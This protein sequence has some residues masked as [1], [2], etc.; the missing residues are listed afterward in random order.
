MGDVA[1]HGSGRDQAGDG[2]HTGAPRVPRWRPAALRPRG[3]DSC[4]A[5]GRRTCRALQGTR[6]SC[7]CPLL[8][9]V[10]C[11]LPLAD[12]RRGLLG[13]SRIRQTQSPSQPPG[14]GRRGCPQRDCVQWPGR[15]RRHQRILLEAH[16]GDRRRVAGIAGDRRRALRSPLGP[17]SGMPGVSR[18]CTRMAAFAAVPARPTPNP[19][20]HPPPAR[21]RSA[22]SRCAP[23]PLSRPSAR[24]LT[25]CRQAWPT[26][27]GASSRST[28]SCSSSARS[29]G[30]PRPPPSE[31]G[32]ER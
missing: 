14:A 5:A 16:A 23:P 12:S 27:A 20:T 7:A 8:P 25:R 3:E 2:A 11:A 10:L 17:G 30:R 6:P 22:C 19:A 26:A 21:A 29:P 18:C 28:T 9:D 1:G 32:A 4:A 24:P 15:R 13:I 31:R